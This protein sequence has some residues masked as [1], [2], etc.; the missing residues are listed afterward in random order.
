METGLSSKK[1]L[2]WSESSK[3]DAACAC[4]RERG[5]RRGERGRE[6]GCIH[7]YIL[8]ILIKTWCWL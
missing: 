7:T 6:R 8:Y 2:K 3:E 5:R 4:E 1:L